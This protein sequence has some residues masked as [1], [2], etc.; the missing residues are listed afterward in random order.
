[1]PGSEFMRQLS[2]IFFLLLGFTS[3]AHANLSSTFAPFQTLLERHLIERALPNNGLVTAFDYQAALDHPETKQ[4]LDEQDQRLAAY[5]I[6]TL[7][8]QAEATAFWINSYNYF[9]ISHILREPVKGK[10]INSVKDYGSFFQPYRV[11]KQELFTLGGKQYSLDGIEKGIL[12]GKEYAAKGW[13]DARIHFAVNCASVGCPPLREMIY[14]EANIDDLLDENT[15]RALAT[16]RH[17][18][19]DGDRLRL[20]QLFEWYEDDF[21]AE[22]GS[23]KAYVLKY[24][25]ENMRAA[26]RATRSID[27]I[28]Y[29]WQLNQPKHFAD[30]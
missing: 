23:V 15:Q 1:M 2:A 28:P 4:L 22:T 16:P 21:V 24:A 6:S 26:I 20:T 10:L 8:Q 11:F 3:H 29:D 14:T 18:T 12:L 9:M 25:P 19:V 7:T 5:P 13:Q 30:L 17:L 27:F